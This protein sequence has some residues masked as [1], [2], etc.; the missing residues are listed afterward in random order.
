MQKGLCKHF[1][2]LGRDEGALEFPSAL[3]GVLRCIGWVAL[4]ALKLVV[5]LLDVLLF[6]PADS[7]H[8]YHLFVLI[9]NS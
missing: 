4:N 6:V 5:G 1:L 3:K 2:H 7:F 8:F 9:L